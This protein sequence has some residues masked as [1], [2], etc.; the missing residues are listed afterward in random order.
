MRNYIKNEI[1]KIKKVNNKMF[2]KINNRRFNKKVALISSN[3]YVNNVKEDILL[4]IELNNNYID[5]DIVS[6]ESI[7]DYKKYDAVIIRS[8]WG[9]QDKIEDFIK[10]INKLKEDNIKAFNDTNILL[11]NISKKEQFD[12]LDKYDIPHINTDFIYKDDINIEN[13]NK[14]VDKDIVVKPIISGGGNNT[15][16]ISKENIK[17]NIK[18]NEIENKYKDVLND[19]NNYLMIQPFIKEINDGELSIVY[20]DNKLSH[21][22]LRYTN[23]FNNNNLIKLVNIKDIK[24]ALE[25][26]DKVNNIIE[27]KTLYKRVDL[28]KIN[29]TYQVMEVE[30]VEPQLFLEYRQNKK[31][32][33]E[34]VNV[35]KNKLN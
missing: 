31:A 12:L 28:V 13:L 35:I 15:Y 24:D 10:F 23:V 11:S 34:F 16:V 27:Y 20:I 14:Y 30:L 17:N 6:W 18:L 25:V 19:V 9:Y 2:T 21:A 7:I 32:L 5:C 22:A 3:K 8:V 29:D 33:K 1:F 26:S 4:K